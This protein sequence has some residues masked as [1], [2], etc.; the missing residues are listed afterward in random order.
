MTQAVTVTHVARRF[1]VL[2]VD[3]ATGNVREFQRVPGLMLEAWTDD[4]ASR[5]CT[6]R[7]TP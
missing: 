5:T 1:A 3:L 4:R 6:G 2:D 7:G